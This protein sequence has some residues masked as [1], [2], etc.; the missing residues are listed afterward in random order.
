MTKPTGRPPGRPRK[1]EPD[2]PSRKRGG[3]TKPIETDP[4][5]F[6]LVR[7]AAIIECHRRTGT[8]I[9]ALKVWEHFAGLTYGKPVERVGNGVLVSYG[10]YREYPDEPH[11]NGWRLASHLPRL[12]C[13]EKTPYGKAAADAFARK[14][15]RAQYHPWF[16]AMLRATM[17]CEQGRAEAE[18]E[19]RELTSCVGESAYF[20]AELRPLLHAH[21]VQRVQGLAK[22]K[23]KLL[24]GF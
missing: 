4:L 5:R 20:Q 8:K 6:M 13:S 23:A 16:R 18:D 7:A 22:S 2:K 3:Q 1:R 15:R 10:E 11:R 19:A 24:P 14:A 9:D 21:A 12:R 17:I